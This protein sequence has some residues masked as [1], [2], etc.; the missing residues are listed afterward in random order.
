VLFGLFWSFFERNFL[1]TLVLSR[2]MFL[3][4]VHRKKA[5]LSGQSFIGMWADFGDIAAQ[6][7]KK[8]LSW[9]GRLLVG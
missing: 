4:Y 9:A 3:L 8:L 2:G 6:T 5:L 7:F 1:V